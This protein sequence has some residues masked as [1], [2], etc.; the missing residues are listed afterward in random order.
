MTSLAAQAKLY[1]FFLLVRNHTVQTGDKVWEGQGVSFSHV[2]AWK[3]GKPSDFKNHMV[4]LLNLTYLQTLF[5]F[6][7]LYCPGTKPIESG[8]FSFSSSND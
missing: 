6:K 7:L 3:T 1:L 5:A 4:K 2:P 8:F